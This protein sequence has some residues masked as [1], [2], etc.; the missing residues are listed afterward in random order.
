MRI[1]DSI[2]RLFFPPK[3]IVCANLI[4]HYAKYPYCER[5]Y[6]DLMSAKI[7]GQSSGLFLEYVNEVYVLFSYKNETV[8]H[9]VFHAKKT[10]S[11]DFA[12]FYADCCQE[13]FEK[14][15]LISRIDTIT[16]ATRRSSEKRREGLDQ[17]KEMAKVISSLTGIEYK[18]LLKRKR[19]SQKQRS[20][21]HE[22]R[23]RN[24]KN[25][26]KGVCQIKGQRILITDD[27]TTTG[28]TLSDCAR[29]LKEAG[30]KSVTVVVFSG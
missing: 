15:D 18:K 5:C 14:T 10:F 28:A 16:Y 29:A 3:C 23:E 26:F 25:L 27:V 21:S 20:L 8:K 4:G 9:S 11:K 1:I 22:D 2:L 19:R 17:A 7:V 13:L 12:Q 6:K 24:V 30:A